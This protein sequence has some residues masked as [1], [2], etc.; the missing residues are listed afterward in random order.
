MKL[1]SIPLLNVLLFAVFGAI[2]FGVAFPFQ[3]APLVGAVVFQSLHFASI[4]YGVAGDLALGTLKGVK[5]Q[6]GVLHRKMDDLMKKVN[7]ENRSALTA[8]EEAEYTRLENEFDGLKIHR[9]RL[10]RQEERN[11]TMST[12]TDTS[13]QDDITDKEK[14]DFSN[15]RLLRGLGLLALGKPLDGIEKE[16][17][18]MTARSA[19]ESGITIEGFAVPSRLPGAEK[20][21]QTAT[22]Q[23]TSP[24]D[25]GG[26]TV[27]TEVGGLIEA[28]WKKN[29]LSAV[30][31]RKFEGLVG[32]QTF[33]TVTSKPTAEAVT[34]IQALTSQ[35]I[36]FGHVDMAPNRRGATI[37]ISKQL[38]IQSSL[39]IEKLVMDLIRKCLDLRLNEDAISVLLA[40]ITGG[41]GN[42]LALGTNGAQPTYLNMVALETTVAGNDADKDSMKY[43]V[44]SKGRGFLKG[45]Q[46]F[47]GTNGDPVWEKGNEIN[48]YPAV[49]SNVVPSN[50]V[51][52]SANN[53]SAMIFGD[54]SQLYVGLWGGADFVV[55]P[56]TLAKKGEVEITAN[57][58]WDV[59]VAQALAFAGIKDALTV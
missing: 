22:L 3:A 55:D 2:I 20:R 30:G 46:K 14:R 58:Y 37:P 24:G 1:S 31:A 35:T 48:G 47:P 5:D 34:E 43:L 49:T 56:Y 57:M 7:T 59:E 28:L 52:G 23:T 54:F 45:T 41:N 39:D 27:A 16:V 26:V 17:H 13:I 15:F 6:M 12:P 44:N 18:D 21:D 19:R 11:R 33:P 25:Q 4:P 10:E 29:F 32:N 51:K 40:A 53:A 8:D 36:L 50:L 42:L 9:T 38:I